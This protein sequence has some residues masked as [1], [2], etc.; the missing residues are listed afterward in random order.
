MVFTLWLEA[1][2]GDKTECAIMQNVILCDRQLCVDCQWCFIAEGTDCYCILYILTVTV[3]KNHRQYYKFIARHCAST[4]FIIVHRAKIST[5]SITYLCW[6]NWRTFWRKTATVSSQRVFFSW[7]HPCSPCNFN[8]RKRTSLGFQYL[9]AH[10]IFR[11]C[12]FGLPSDSRTENSIE[13]S[14]FFLRRGGHFSSGKL[15]GRKN[16]DFLS[17]L[18]K[19]EQR[20]K[21]YIELRREYFE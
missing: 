8:H 1:E 2:Q 7:K 10:L 16:F 14:S 21:K 13:K 17:G 12:P 11:I 18:Q 3:Y 6:C 15:V 20:A 4:S 9:D 19:L 5:W